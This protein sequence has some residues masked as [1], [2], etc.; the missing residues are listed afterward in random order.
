MTFRKLK[1]LFFDYRLIRRRS[2]STASSAVIFE[3]ALRGDYFEWIDAVFPKDVDIL[4]L[5]LTLRVRRS[6]DCGSIVS[7]LVNHENIFFHSPGEPLQ[8]KFIQQLTRNGFT[9][10]TIGFQHGF[11]GKNVP[12]SLDSVIKKCNSQYYVSFEKEFST[13]LQRHT[14]AKVIED[15]LEAPETSRVDIIPSSL[16]C[17]FDAPDKGKLLSQVMQVREFITVN[18]VS[19]L[20]LKFHPSTSF[21]KRWIISNFLRKYLT[22]PPSQFVGSAICWD[23]KVKYEL[24]MNDVS[25][26]SFDDFG[27]FVRLSP[28][29]TRNTFTEHVRA[30]VKNVLENGAA[31]SGCEIGAHTL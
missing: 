19:Q 28:C 4:E 1:F 25:V 21:I 31:S 20:R 15:L 7:S 8:R 12:R 30:A 9:G 26:F 18:S 27:C 13:R 10:Y 23:S 11:I 24:M 3:N 2:S 29:Q 14:R 22:I 16:E 6:Q 5:A 17:Y